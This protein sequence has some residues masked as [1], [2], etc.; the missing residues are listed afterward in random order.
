[1]SANGSSISPRISGNGRF[2]IYTSFAT[3]LPGPAGATAEGVVYRYDVS[4]GSTQLV[5][6]TLTGGY[7]AK[8][9][10]AEDIS[11]TGRYVVFSSA[12]R[13]LAPGDDN[14]KYDVFRW[15]ANTDTTTLVSRASDGGGANK[16]SIASAVS[17]NGS[18][19]F[20]SKATNIVPLA[21][22]DFGADIYYWDPASGDTTLV[23]RS[24]DG[25]FAHGAS[26][27]LDISA[28]GHYIAFDSLATDLVD[29]D[30][31]GHQAF[32][33]STATGTTKRISTSFDDWPGGAAS[34]DVSISDNGRHVA[35]TTD[36]LDTAESPPRAERRRLRPRHRREHV[37]VND[38][39]RHGRQQHVVPARDQ[40][41]WR[42]DRVQ[43]LAS[44][45][46]RDIDTNKTYDVYVWT[47]TP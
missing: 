3:D 43:S 42:A 44:N 12:A 1:M 18:V 40:R 7:P 45:L 5:S 10:G 26:N 32:I 15:D 24:F 33:F 9:A 16:A 37:G 13:N 14:G 38:P 8:G 30:S 2:V 29:D 28:N 41:Q 34:L 39:E 22:N 47:R 46:P 27:T 36:R 31:V 11:S 17:R 25:G 35:Y 19:V 4:T 6:H 20:R 21:G 23:T